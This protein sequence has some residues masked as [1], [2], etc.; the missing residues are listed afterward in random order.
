METYKKV[1]MI[2][3]IIILF[4]IL[5]IL[6]NSLVKKDNINKVDDN[7]SSNI[8]NNNYYGSLDKGNYIWAGAMNLA[9]NELSEKIIKEKI[10]LSGNKE[11]QEI[12]NKFNSSPFSKKDLDEKSYY[13]KAGYGQKTVEEINTESKKKFPQKSFSDLKIV[14]GP[15]DIISYAYF[16]KEV[17]YKEKFVENKNFIFNN[18][19]VFS[20][21]AKTPQQKQT[22][23]ILKY[24]DD[25][26]FIVK[27]ELKDDSDELILAKGYDMS[28]PEKV[29]KEINENDKKLLPSLSD[30][31]EF[32]VPKLHLDYSRTYKKLLR[33]RFLNKDFTGYIISKMF[34]NIK[35]DMDEEG[36]RVEN[37]AAIVMEMTAALPPREPIKIK[38]IILDKPYWL[39]MKRTESKRPYF[40]LGV[41]N[42]NIMID[43][44]TEKE[45]KKDEKQNTENEKKDIYTVEEILK[46]NLKEGQLVKVKAKPGSCIQLKV[47]ADYEGPGG[48]CELIDLK[49]NQKVLTGI[50]LSFL[51]KTK[52]E[53]LVQGNI[54]YCGGKKI[55]KHICGLENVKILNLKK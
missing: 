8:S 19:K 6:K 47:S 42:E 4:I 51:D 11:V 44:D 1:L 34:E 46:S 10:K 9:W 53:I 30:D 41:N 23:K 2:I 16:L 38:R 3:G 14:L 20:F 50:G 33:K 37:E 49:N 31:D 40:I 45:I 35:F 13:I 27:I 5:I 26:N 54:A 32:E 7:N 17:K 39:I 22:I 29:L 24:T 48:G 25:D 12:V 36:A 18:K 28:N 15:S 21:Y 55:K 43:K 52:K